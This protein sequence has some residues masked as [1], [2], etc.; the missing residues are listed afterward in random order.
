M[1]KKVVI[2]AD[3][4]AGRKSAIFSKNLIKQPRNEQLSPLSLAARTLG[5]SLIA[6]IDKACGCE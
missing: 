6:L 1:F 3:G 4:K 5:C 2:F